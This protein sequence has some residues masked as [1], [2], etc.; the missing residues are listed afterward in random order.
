M[1]ETEILQTPLHAL[2]V[3]LGARMAP[4]AGYEMPIQYPIGHSRRASAHPRP[5]GP[6]RRLAY[7]AGVARRAGPRNDRARA[8][9][10]LPR[11]HRRPRARA[12]A[13]HANC[14]TPRAASSTISWSRARPAPTGASR[15]SSTRR[16]R[17]SISRCCEPR[18]PRRVE[19]T[20]RDDGRARRLA[21]AGRGAAVLAR[22]APGAGVEAMAVHERRAR[23]RSAASTTE[24]L[25]LRLHRRGRLRNFAARARRRGV[26]APPSRRRFE[27]EPIGLGARD[28][29]RL[30][31]GLCLY[32]HELDETTDP[33]EAGLAWSIQKRR[34]ARGRISRRGAHPGGARRRPDAQARRLAA[35]R[36]ARPARDGAE[37]V[38][39]RRRASSASSPRAASARASARRSRW[40]M[41]RAP[42]ASLGDAGR[43]RRARQGR[44]PRASPPCPSI[45][46]PI[47]AADSRLVSPDRRRPPC[48]S[49]RTTNT[50]ASTDD[51]ATVGISD[52]AQSQLGDVV[53][54]RTAG[55]RR[56]VRQGRRSGGGRE[57][58][59]GE[60]RLL[61]RSRGEVVAVNDALARPV[62][63]HQRGRAGARLVV[64]ARSSP[65]PASSTR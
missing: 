10:A 41:S 33:I 28:T 20:V 34:R 64:Q 15:S 5:S 52:H 29:L 14:S 62:R 43:P 47:I 57:R 42:H 27:V 50:S 63:P 6:V 18:C 31:A 21:G 9:G 56:Q 19:L 12:P 61:R 30:E 32:G 40:A 3:E 35:S 24:I 22:L 55:G 2:H 39:T 4:F 7:G 60:R 45:P 58:E 48:A 37:I 49:P 59:G 25:A 1:S 8:G 13:L 51:V 38:R 65:I 16:A 46:T 26:R 23:S 11:R 54:R 44:C 53:Y 36:A 17:R